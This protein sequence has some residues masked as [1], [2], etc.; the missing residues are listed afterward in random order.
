MKRPATSIMKK[1]AAVACTSQVRQRFIAHSSADNRRRYKRNQMRLKRKPAAAA[2]SKVR[3]KISKYAAVDERAGSRHRLYPCCGKRKA[4]CT[5]DYTQ[6]HDTLNHDALRDLINYLSTAD[7]LTVKDTVDSGVFLSSVD[8]QHLSMSMAFRYCLVFR[9]FSNHSTWAALMPCIRSARVNWNGI[10]KAL[11]NIIDSDE[12]MFGGLFYPATLRK[13]RM[14]PERRWRA[15][16]RMGAADRE[17]LSLRLLLSAIPSKEC[18][19]YD[20]NPSRENWRM[21]VERYQSNVASTTRGLFSDYGMKCALDC[22]V[23]GSASR[24]PDSMISVWPTDC[25]GYVKAFK[26]LWRVSVP[27][28]QRFL[29]LCYIFMEVS[30]HHGGRLRF[31]EVCMHLCWML[32]ADAIRDS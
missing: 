20:K 28:D 6:L 10:R 32:R 14:L 5:C 19:N 3:K 2:S 27:R 15:C 30:K 25:S 12:K 17:T 18:A 11:Q 24:F 16:K 21:F 8:I 22:L 4:L 9:R 29:A 7:L 31:P 1:P 23:L 26:K 13:Y